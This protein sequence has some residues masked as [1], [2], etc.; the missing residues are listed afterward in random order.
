MRKFL[1]LPPK[2]YAKTSNFTYRKFDV[3]TFRRKYHKSQD[4]MKFKSTKFVD[5]ENC[6]EVKFPGTRRKNAN[7]SEVCEDS[8]EN[9]Y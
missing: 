9:I 2:I 7:E 8:Y 1:F 5:T 3:S 4:L 6:S